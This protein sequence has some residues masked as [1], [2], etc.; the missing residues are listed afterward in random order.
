MMRSLKDET[1]ANETLY[2][3][4]LAGSILNVATRPSEVPTNREMEE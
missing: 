1:P 2:V 3:P 4:L